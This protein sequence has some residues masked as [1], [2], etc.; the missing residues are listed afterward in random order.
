MRK[1]TYQGNTSATSAIYEA[2]QRN[3]GCATQE[4]Y[5][6]FSPRF[7]EKTIKRALENLRYGQRKIENRGGGTGQLTAWYPIRGEDPFI[8][9]AEQLLD[10]LQGLTPAKKRERLAGKL[11]LVATG[12]L[13]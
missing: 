9:L 12:D 3:P 11:M 1:T 10:E 4:L 2:I 13:P 8:K 7:E 6:I 5:R